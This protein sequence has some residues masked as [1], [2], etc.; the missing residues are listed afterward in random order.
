M[1][2]SSLHRSWVSASA[3]VM[4][5]VG[6]SLF[7]AQVAAEVKGRELSYN[8]GGVSMQGYYAYD[9]AWTSPKPG[10][11]VVHE[12]WGHN[13]YARERARKLA[14]MGYAAFSMDLYGDGKTADHPKDAKAFS[15]AAWS[16]PVAM[17]ARFE[18]AEQQLKAQPETMKQDVAAIGYCFGGGV[19]LEMARQGKPFAAVASFHGSLAPK[20]RAVSG[21]V[22]TPILVA[23]GAADPLI[24]P[25]H[26]ADFHVEMV[27]AGVEYEFISYPGV[28]HAFTNPAADGFAEKFGMP[29]GYSA[30]ADQDSWAQL[31][32]FLA[33]A[34]AK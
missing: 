32:G 13:D 34:F 9:D 31:E 28:K 25:E 8:V 11:L 21:V 4:L 18:A 16:D 27:D 29:L 7:S 26:V 5:T 12:W 10:V 2:A 33:R 1:F 20:T 23:H 22:T 14:A 17:K 24:K 30:H 3:P 15:S 19:V 6:I